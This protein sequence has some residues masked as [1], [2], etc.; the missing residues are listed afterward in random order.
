MVLSY[1]DTDVYNVSP[2]LN[3][4]YPVYIRG[5]VAVTVTVKNID[6][7]KRVIEVETICRV[8]RKKVITGVAEVYIPKA[9]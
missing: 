8:D 2:T 4:K 3:F 1:Q 7:D 5:T 6:F 9:S